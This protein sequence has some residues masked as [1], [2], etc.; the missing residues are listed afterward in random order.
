MSVVS[1]LSAPGIWSL[2]ATVVGILGFPVAAQS[3]GQP[4]APAVAPAIRQAPTDKKEALAAVKEAIN[5]LDVAA[6]RGALEAG[7]DPNARERLNE[8]TLTGRLIQQVMLA[9]YPGWAN[10]P[11]L[12][13][14][15][16]DKRVAE[17]LTM[18]FE[19]GGKLDLIENPLISPAL[20]NTAKVTTV[21]IDRGADPNLRKDDVTPLYHAISYGSDAVER[22]LID[23]GAIPLSDRDD[24]Q[25]RLVGAA[26]A[27]DLDKLRALVGRG[28]DVKTADL[29]GSTA[30]SR[31]VS[32]YRVAVVEFLLEQNANPNQ[33][34]RFLSTT[35]SYP[36][37]EAVRASIARGQSTQP[38]AVFWDG[39]QMVELLLKK[40]AE[41]SRA[42]SVDGMTPLHIAAK[43]GTVR[44]AK[45][46]IEA[47]AK[48]MPMDAAGKTP[49]DYAV[50]GPMI[51]LLKDNGAKER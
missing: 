4:P 38:E 41:V 51:Q 44:T 46:L 3:L 29:S 9:K 36:L 22:V 5:S 25:T 34:S 17:M 2:L 6:L 35:G 37:H 45:A 8:S 24:L 50:S 13:A 28:G 7:V 10:G 39:F 20:Y 47:G 26:C 16:V 31:A 12:G 49:L 18:M 43:S 21:L 30:L 1:R 19:K 40:N 33:E 42:R 32:F 15:E 27:G 48:V 23:R 11:K 14:E